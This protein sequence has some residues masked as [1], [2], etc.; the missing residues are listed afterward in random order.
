[1]IFVS[2]SVTTANASAQSDYSAGIQAYLDGD[3]EQA[4][5]YWLKSAKD[6]D[7]K[8]MFN[9]G[10]L[11][12]RRQLS[13]AD[14]GKSEKWFRLSARSGYAAASYHLAMWLSERGSSKIEIN[15]L[16]LAADKAGFAPASVK[17]GKTLSSPLVS[18]GTAIPNTITPE[19]ISSAPAQRYR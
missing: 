12:Q 17:L 10:L 16:L 7:A 6:K 13:N 8:S 5:S 18:T 15:K 1:M 14:D 2:L 4:Q 19:I 11:H 9:L 3:F